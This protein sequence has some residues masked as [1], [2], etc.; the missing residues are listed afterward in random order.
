MKKFLTFALMF[1][2]VIA[3]ADAPLIFNG[4]FAK[5]LV[6]DGWQMPVSGRKF[7]DMTTDPTSGSGYSAA[8]GSI[9]VSASSVGILWL[10]TGSADTA[11]TNV[12]S[13]ISGWS[14]TG[15]AGL[16]AASN[17]LGTTDAVDLIFKANNAEVMRLTSAGEIDTNISQ[18]YAQFNSTGGLTNFSGVSGSI[19][20]AGSAG[21]PVTDSTKL[22]YNNNTDQLVVGAGSATSNYR[23]MVKQADANFGSGFAIQDAT[24]YGSNTWEQVVSGGFLYTR[25][26]GASLGT[27]TLDNVG[28]AGV[29]TQS[30]G[31]GLHVRNEASRTGDATFRTQAVASQTGDLI[32]GSNSGGS[33]LFSFDVL[34]N[35]NVPGLAATGSIYLTGSVQ[36]SALTPSMP[37]VLNGSNVIATDHISLASQVSGSLPVA[38]GGTNSIASLNNNRIMQSSG[39]AIVEASAITASRALVSDTNGI[40]TGSAVTQTELEYLFGVT[41][42]VQTQLGLKQPLDSTLTSLAAYNTNGILTQTSADTFTGRTLVTAS[43]RIAITNG[44]GVSGNPT[45][46]VNEANIAITSLSGTLGVSKGGTGLTST[47]SNGQIP[48]G[49]GTGFSL[50]NITAGDNVTITNGSGTITV[51]ASTGSSGGGMYLLIFGGSGTWPGSPSNCTADPCTIYHESGPTADWVSS[52]QRVSSAIFNVNIQSGIFSGADYVCSAIATDW[53]GI[54]TAWVGMQAASPSATQMPIECRDSGGGTDC[55]VLLMCTD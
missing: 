42:S 21:E 25:N 15:N 49:N 10:K 20:L 47:P 3:L 19:M 13:A 27:W 34:G 22:W 48:I 53:G 9:G 2:S 6:P 16:S 51:S 29:N 14:V 50:A 54:N 55:I 30:P 44:D 12:L 8:S 26:P 46:D 28:R 5:F 35:L 24:T 33:R 38:N 41:G 32:Q 36:M 11:W 17:F 37:L 52:V 43:N 23:L 31:A 4:R 45:F 39:G 1:V 40:P 7:I 18:G